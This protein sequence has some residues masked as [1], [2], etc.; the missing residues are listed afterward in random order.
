MRVLV[1]EDQADIRQ[2]L[3]LTLQSASFLV[4]WAETAKD[5]VFKAG[6]NK[7][8]VIVL[9]LNLPDGDGMT[10]C[11][12]IR[13]D[14]VDTPVLMLTIRDELQDIV[15]GFDTG[16]DD[17]MTKPYSPQE[18]IARLKS[19]ARRGTKQRTS[20]YKTDYLEMNTRARS[21]IFH[22][23]PV[24]LTRRE[25]DLLQH[26][27]ERDGEVVQREDLWEQVWGWDDYPLHNTVDVHIKKLRDKL[28]DD[29]G[30]VIQTVRGI[31]Y[32]FNTE[33]SK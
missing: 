31:G 11:H 14:G 30:R 22:G 29:K 7:Y 24:I 6:V 19:L 28:Q 13:Q 10:I 12:Q 32:R 23:K 4:D 3:I 25:F 15:K 26:L 8:N 16:A 33:Y 20:I 17:Y 1:V 18:L 27:L 5:A 21:L 2:A 9:D